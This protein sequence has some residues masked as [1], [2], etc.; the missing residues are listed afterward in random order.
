ML[1]ILSTISFTSALLM[2]IFDLPETTI[3]L[4]LGISLVVLTVAA[5][6][7]FKRAEK[8]SERIAEIHFSEH[9]G[10]T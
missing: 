8:T 3:L 7:W 2:R 5:R 10:R 1:A 4:F 6:R 9:G